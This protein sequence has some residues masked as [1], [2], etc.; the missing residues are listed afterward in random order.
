MGVPSQ[1]MLIFESV[2]DIL[3]DQELAY[4]FRNILV[5]SFLKNGNIKPGGRDAYITSQMASK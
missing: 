1:L 3:F 2:H 5:L 4:C